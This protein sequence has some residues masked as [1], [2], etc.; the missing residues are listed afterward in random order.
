[1][2]CTLNLSK[3]TMNE[4]ARANNEGVAG[5][6]DISEAITDITLGANEVKG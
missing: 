6:N 4:I 2:P 1:L 3:D 5:I